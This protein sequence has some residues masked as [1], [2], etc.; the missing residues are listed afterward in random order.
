MIEKRAPFARQSYA[1]KNRTKMAI[2]HL[3]AVLGYLEKVMLLNNELD[4]LKNYSVRKK[5]K[6]HFE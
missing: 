4:E 1:G 5:G 2:F 3:C 6:G